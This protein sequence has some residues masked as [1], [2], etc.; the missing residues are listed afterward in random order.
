[1]KT[2]YDERSRSFYLIVQ[3]LTIGKCSDSERRKEENMVHKEQEK[4]S[5]QYRS[6]CQLAYPD[7]K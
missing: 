2:H 6:L 1:M 5:K 4:K 7:R 3:H